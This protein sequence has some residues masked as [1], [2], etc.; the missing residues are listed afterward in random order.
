MTSEQCPEDLS[1]WTRPVFIL[2]ET[3]LVA[4]VDT[5]AE[6]GGSLNSS[7]VSRCLLSILLLLPEDSRR[8]D[9]GDGLVNAFCCNRGWRA[10]GHTPHGD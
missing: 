2:G 7:F 5:G 10:A 4:S 3:V 8:A 6:A 9:L 1:M